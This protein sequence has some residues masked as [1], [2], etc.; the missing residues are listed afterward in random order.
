VNATTQAVLEFLRRHAEPVS[1]QATGRALGVSRSAVSKH[2]EAL[3]RAGYRI[4]SVPRRGHRLLSSPDTPRS[5]QVSP[6]LTTRAIGRPIEYVATVDSTNAAAARAAA[7]GAAEGLVVVA[8]AQTAGRGRQQRT[9]SSP[10][11]C[12]L[13]FSVLLRPRVLP[14]RVA[15]ISL[16]AAVAVHQALADVRPEL[17]L[18][19][20]WP[21]DILASS[22]EKLCGI[23]CEADLE[24]DLVH[25]AIVGIG[26]NVNMREGPAPIRGVAT[27]LYRLTRSVTPRPLVLASVLNRLEAA[28]E[29]WR[30]APDLGPLLPY[31]DRH[32]VLT[33]RQVDV[34]NVAG[35]FQGR[36]EGLTADGRLRVRTADGR[37]R[38]VDAGD[39]QR[40]RKENAT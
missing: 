19:I 23:L 25:H 24:A 18:G 33:G 37:R 4:E 20:K 2:V 22:G 35:R 5:E 40:V 31:L 30:T 38:T 28:Y 32:S 39:V 21:N 8:D 16:V 13:Y 29:R 27:S 26:L 12:N 11:G 7:A 17:D 14:H 36:A 34:S 6:L 9:W 10:P 3:R 1:G 15:Q